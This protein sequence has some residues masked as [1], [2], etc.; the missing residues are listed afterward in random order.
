VNWKRNGRYLLSLLISV[1]LA[2]LVGALILGITGHSPLKAYA[3]MIEGAFRNPR[4]RG[5]V[6]E[7]AMVLALCGLACDLG[8]RV[9]IF[10]V[11]GEGQ[12]LLGA[13]MSCQVGV[14]L[15]GQS[16]WLVYPLA[17]L[18]AI[19]TG[20]IYALIPGVLKVKVKVNE[21]ITTIMLNTIAASVC[22]YLAKGPWKNANK[23]MVAA[24]SSLDVRHWF[25]GLIPG[26]NLSTAI[27]AAAIIAFLIWY[28]MQKTTPGFEMKLTGQ[29]PRFAR[30]SGMNVDR[31]VIVCMTIS[32]ALCGLV[33]MFRV[34]GAE[35]IFKSSVSHDYYFEGLM[36]AMIARYEP[37]TAIAMSLL[38]A[39]LKIGAAGME[40]N[41]RVPNQIYL[42][43]QTLVIF[44]M[45]AE[46]GVR[47]ALARWLD[48][49]RK[50][51]EVQANA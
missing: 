18:A 19:L 27:F 43:I 4:N 11:G 45:A 5:D 36:V 25:S 44:F 2:F 22:Q 33:G 15:Q 35:H 12:L 7:Y 21:V 46:G 31:K 20:G 16:P 48:D 34:Y 13:I 47:A 3:A 14:A 23:N 42:I 37:V 6:L 39:V 40:L 10:N 17:A 41:A 51:K 26:S 9:G 28:V 30:F 8:S 49:R 38:F 50:A 29:N 1:L 24:T 32:G